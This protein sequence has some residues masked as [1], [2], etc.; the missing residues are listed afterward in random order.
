MARILIVEDEPKLRQHVAQALVAEGFVVSAHETGAAALETLAE[1]SFDLVL[2]DLM[3]PGQNGWQV[4]DNMKA[5]G[6][7]T[8]VLVMSAISDTTH[9]IEALNRGAVDYLR[10]PFEIGELIAR[11]RA[12]IRKNSPHQALH[13]VVHDLEIDL[14]QRKVLFKGN[15]VILTKREFMILELLVA[16]CNRIVSKAMIA[17][18]VWEVNFDMGSNVIEV[19]MSQLRK[20]LDNHVITTRVGMGYCIEGKLV[21]R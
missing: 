10:K 11:V 9:V 21:T 18:K 2:L 8:S 1:H 5:F 12:A 14:M 20:K 13:Y 15:E 19:H 3:L 4:L 6:L 17:E 16:N 7:D